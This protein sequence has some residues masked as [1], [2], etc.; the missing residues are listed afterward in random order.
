MSKIEIDYLHTAI[1]KVGLL[2]K[3][4]E[5]QNGEVDYGCFGDAV[6]L[7]KTMPYDGIR[8][9]V[10]ACGNTKQKRPEKVDVIIREYV[11][12][13]NAGMRN[14]LK[15]CESPVEQ[16]FLAEVIRKLWLCPT[17]M[18]KMFISRQEEAVDLVVVP[19]YLIECGDARYRVDFKFYLQKC[20]GVGDYTDY[21]KTVVEIDGHDFHEKTKGQAS[22]DK[23]RDRDI[24]RAGYFVLRFSGSD[25]FRNPKK[26]VTEV[27]DHMTEQQKKIFDAFTD[28]NR[29]TQF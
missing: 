18:E 8:E 11:A 27:M 24:Q 21:G 19:Q 22:R 4:F 2:A 6:E 23:K 26:C 20:E 28:P 15:L 29:Q 14:A 10:I 9:E 5:E 3:L 7:A 13:A 12:A 25:V 16:I 17:G 1:A